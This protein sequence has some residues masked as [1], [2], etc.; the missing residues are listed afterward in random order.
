MESLSCHSNEST[1]VTA[2]KHI[3]IEDDIMNISAKF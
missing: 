1:R 2:I 3:F